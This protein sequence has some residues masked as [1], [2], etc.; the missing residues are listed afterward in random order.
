MKEGYINSA[1]VG[2][3]AKLST[4]LTVMLGFV[5]GLALGAGVVWCAPRETPSR[6]HNAVSFPTACACSVVV[7][8]GMEGEALACALGLLAATMAASLKTVDPVMLVHHLATLAVVACNVLEYGGRVD[9]GCTLRLLSVELATVWL[10]ASNLLP[11]GGVA[12][13]CR[14]VFVLVFFATRLGGGALTTMDPSYLA[15]E[16]VWKPTTKRVIVVS[17]TLIQ[18]C[19]MWWGGQ[20]VAGL[21]KRSPVS[22]D[23]VAKRLVCV[24]VPAATVWW[25][26]AARAGGAPWLVATAGRRGCLAASATALAASS[27]YHLRSR[28][29][30]LVAALVWLWSAALV[31]VSVGGHR[32]LADRLYR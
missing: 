25:L 32:L 1:T 31:L 22:G 28:G 9:G 6:F 2:L 19:S 13:L 15:I 26:A 5:C 24:A 16:T 27:L 4:T 14:L 12:T 21:A 20:I 29:A 10:N 11:R 7:L 23:R 3:Q 17:S 18:A 30:R 8:G